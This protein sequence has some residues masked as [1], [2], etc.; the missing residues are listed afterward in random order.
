MRSCVLLR[1]KTVLPLKGMREQ[2]ASRPPS[3]G[4]WVLQEDLVSNR[5]QGR[6]SNA[7]ERMRA[8]CVFGRGPDGLVLAL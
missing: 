1:E 6:L 7:W 8:A 2:G 4:S 3:D 5:A